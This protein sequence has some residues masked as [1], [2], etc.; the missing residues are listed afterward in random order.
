MRGTG[1]V[2]VMVIL[3]LSWAATAGAVD[4][5]EDPG[6]AVLCMYT[7]FDAESGPAGGDVF[8][9]GYSPLTPYETYTVMYHI[10]GESSLLEAVY[11]SV[12]YRQ[13]GLDLQYGV[14]YGYTHDAYAPWVDGDIVG[15]VFEADNV[16]VSFHPPLPHAGG[17][18]LVRHTQV[19]FFGLPIP[20]AAVEVYFEPVVFV[21]FPAE[22]GYLDAGGQGVSLP[23]Y[24]NNAGYDVAQPVFEF[25]ADPLPVRSRSLTAVKQ[26]FR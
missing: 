20:G 4:P 5:P 14:H 9:S 21:G 23:M 17:P 6:V 10:R 7:A 18:L 1:R 19:M 26:L 24:P 25:R 22:M 2:V 11:Y 13:A 16:L 8:Y 3:G 15:V 12:H